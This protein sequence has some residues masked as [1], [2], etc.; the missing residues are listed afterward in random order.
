MSVLQRMS[1]LAVVPLGAVVFVQGKRLRRD[2]PKLPDAALPWA[3]ST[4]ADGSVVGGA[5]MATA[6]GTQAVPL[7]MLVLGDSTAAGVGADTQDDALPGTL[8]RELVAR[9]RRPVSWRAIGENGATARDLR[10]RFIDEA[11]AE[12]FDFIF[13]TVGAND[14]LGLRARGAF[15]RD[16]RALLAQ[17]REANPQA[18]IMMSS[19]P[20]FKRFV[21][22]PNPLRWNLYL[23]SQSL[24]AEAR[25]IVAG[26]ARTIM[27]PPPPPYTEGF[28]ASDLFHPSA[29]GYRDWACFA[30][31]DA[32]ATGQL[33]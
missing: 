14:A 3:G 4:P 23:H 18:I 11:T 19:L 10:E 12:S 16:I 9:W 33:T 20:A 31:A 1:R 17:L 5:S 2:T 15:G 32:F 13:L 21:L 30:I 28:F 25:G 22:L 7:R 6:T 29:Q 8:A 27:S 24:E 26:L